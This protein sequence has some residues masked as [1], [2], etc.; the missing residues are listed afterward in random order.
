MFSP[1]P[2]FPKNEWAKAG[3]LE[4]DSRVQSIEKNLIFISA[5]QAVQ[6]STDVIDI[7]L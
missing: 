4:R 7:C 1:C 6:S 2:S 5:V 3:V